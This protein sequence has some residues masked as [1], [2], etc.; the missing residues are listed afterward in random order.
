GLRLRNARF[1]YSVMNETEPSARDLGR[2][3]EDLRRHR[4]RA[5]IYNKQVSDRLTQQLLGIARE[6]GVPVVPV[7]ETQPEGLSYSDWMLG[8][9]DA[10]AAALEGPPA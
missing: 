10:L 2:F 3:E 8:E 7:T 9:L 1:Q 5:L 6:S 4:V